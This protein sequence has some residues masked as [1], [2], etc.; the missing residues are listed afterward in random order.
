M[1]QPAAIDLE[2]VDT[3]C[4]N[5]F[6]LSRA[7]KKKG[8]IRMKLVLGQVTWD[9]TRKQNSLLF[10]SQRREGRRWWWWWKKNLCHQRR[11]VAKAKHNTQ[12]ASSHDQKYFAALASPA[13]CCVT[14]FIWCVSKGSKN[15][16]K[17]IIL[18]EKIFLLKPTWL[19]RKKS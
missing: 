9:A 4:V 10:Y 19:C 15:G 1:N 17:R 18:V 11:T 16:M 3:A 7:G 2:Q 6:L 14:A 8:K 13:G 12:S 5:M